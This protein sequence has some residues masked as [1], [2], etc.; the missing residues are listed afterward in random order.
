MREILRIKILELLADPDRRTRMG[1]WGRERVEN[2][3]AWTY[4]AN[5]LLE[6]Y[7]TL[8]AQ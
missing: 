4:S 5:V 1:S 2:E 6:A 8:F 3:L 7:R